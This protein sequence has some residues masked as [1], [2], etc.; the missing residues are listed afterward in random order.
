MRIKK[1]IHFP[2]QNCLYSMSILRESGHEI[3]FSEK[4]VNNNSDLYIFTSSIVNFETE[5]ENIKK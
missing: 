3:I 4:L 2:P 5:I 1:A